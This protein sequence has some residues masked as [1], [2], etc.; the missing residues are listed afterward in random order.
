MSDDWRD[1]PRFRQ[2]PLKL[3][4]RTKEKKLSFNVTPKVVQKAKT[5]WNSFPP[6]DKA[7]YNSFN[8][9]LQ[10]GDWGSA[11]DKALL[12]SPKD[13]L[14]L[15]G[16]DYPK[17]FYLDRF[18]PE[19]YANFETATTRTQL[20]NV[21]IKIAENNKGKYWNATSKYPVSQNEFITEFFDDDEDK[22]KGLE[23]IWREDGWGIVGVVKEGANYQRYAISIDEINTDEAAENFD[24]NTGEVNLA[25]VESYF[26]EPD[27]ID[28]NGTL[29]GAFIPTLNKK[30][31]KLEGREIAIARVHRVMAPI[32]IEYTKQVTIVRDGLLHIRP[33]FGETMHKAERIWP[34]S[35]ADSDDEVI[36]GAS[37]TAF[38]VDDKGHIVTNYHVVKGG[39]NK[40]KIS[41]KNKEIEAKLIREDKQLDLALLETGIENKSFISVSNKKPE[42]L[43]DIIACGFPR[44]KSLS[45]DL[46]LT[47]GIIS[48][49]KGERDNTAHI[50]TDLALNS[51]NSGGPIVDK[52]TGQLV[53]VAVSGIRVDDT[54]GINFGIK[55]SQVKDFLDANN[56]KSSKWSLKRNIKRA[57]LLNLL[58]SSTVYI[59]FK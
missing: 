33:P 32:T 50:Q 37:G 14:H 57:E 39:N 19:C 41:Y 17:I 13:T 59:F 21:K 18:V 22:I 25:D 42:K 46:K 38:F 51:G 43:Q 55:A 34:I 45:N 35:K 9:F 11:K 47:S 30:K 26:E 6:G 1:D 23:G 44:G 48:A 27:D 49:L 28:I 4:I 8:Q 40:I 24:D 58:E 3:K 36:D 31:F 2:K 52:E 10:S 15:Y 16:I 12:T 54:Q 29:D 7:S 53:A 20:R 56:I 5:V